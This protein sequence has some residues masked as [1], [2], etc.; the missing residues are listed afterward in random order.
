MYAGR[1]MGVLSYLWNHM[2]IRNCVWRWHHDGDA[3][4][5]LPVALVGGAH[6]PGGQAVVL[7]LL[8][9]GGRGRH[10]VRGRHPLVAGHRVARHLQYALFIAHFN[11]R[12]VSTRTT[13]A[14]PKQLFIQLPLILSF[15]SVSFQRIPAYLVDKINYKSAFVN[16]KCGRR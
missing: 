2:V 10:H 9:R 13:S 8:D 3:P 14:Q 11:C 12:H 6:V 5:R 7:D 1:A 16:Q 4:R 15:L